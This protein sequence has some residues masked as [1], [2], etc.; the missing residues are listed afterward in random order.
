VTRRAALAAVLGLTGAFLVLAPT[1][2]AVSAPTAAWWSRLATTTPT[3][4]VPAG[5]PVPAPTT[6]DTVPVGATVPEGNLLVE[7]TAEGATA[8]AAIRWEL[9]EGES[10]PSLTL[11]VGEGSSLNAASIVL[12]CR[13]ATMWAPPETSP[14][15]WDAKPLVEG[16][17]CVNGI[18]ADDMTSVTFGVQPLVSGTVLDVVLVPGEEPA[19]ERPAEVPEPPVETNRSSFRWVFEQPSPDSLEVVAGSGFEEGS[20]DRFI[21]P[22]VSETPDFGATGSVG[23]SSAPPPPTSPAFDAPAEAAAPAL[24]PQDLAPSVPDVSNSVPAAATEGPANRT[25]GFI[26][27]ALSAL[28]GGWAYFTSNPASTIGLGRFAGPVPAGAP[29]VASG[30]GVTG[31]LSRF[32]RPRSSPPTRLS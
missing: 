4:E 7:G 32:A 16:F 11:P 23:D 26:L 28:V 3:D 8:V 5:L 17:G 9:G 10:S 25:I 2:D 29:L 13:A 6:P 19:L 27:L 24:E 14:G 18:V 30:E 21:D 12:A 22:S 31:G 20:G 15:T 1:A